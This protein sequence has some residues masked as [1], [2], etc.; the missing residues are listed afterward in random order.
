MLILANCLAS[1]I[2]FVTCAA[3]DNEQEDRS[4]YYYDTILFIGMT[5]TFV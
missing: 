1:F 2:I 4:K 5:M 3:A